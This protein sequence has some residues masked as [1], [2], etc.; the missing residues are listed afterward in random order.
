MRKV[1]LNTAQ[2]AYSA[3][4]ESDK[5]QEKSPNGINCFESPFTKYHKKAK[6]HLCHFVLLFQLQTKRSLSIFL[7]IEITLPYFLE[8]GVE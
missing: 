6:N 2:E 8:F 1:P 5:K 7:W 4:I 3:K